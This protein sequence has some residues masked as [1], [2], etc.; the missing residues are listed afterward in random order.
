MRR[1]GLSPPTR[2]SRGRAPPDQPRGRS[3]PA[4]TGKPR[5]G[6]RAR[7]LPRVYPRPHGEATSAER[8]IKLRTGLSPPTRGSRRPGCPHA[9]RRGS[10]P[11]H[12]GKPALAER[13]GRSRRVYPRPHGEARDRKLVEVTFKGLSPP[14]RGSRAQCLTDRRGFRSIPAH[15]GKP[16]SAS[17]PSSLPSVYPRPHGEAL[18]RLG[19]RRRVLGL[20]P[21]TRGSR[22]SVG[23]TTPLMRSIPAHTGKPI[24]VSISRV[25]CAVYPRPHG[26]ARNRKLFAP[27][28]TG[29][30]PPTR[31]SHCARVASSH[32]HGSIPA[33]T[34]KPK[35]RTAF[36]VDPSV[37]PRPHGEATMASKPKSRAY[38]LSPPTRGSPRRRRRPN[39][40]GRS[41]P[42]HTGKPGRPNI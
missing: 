24:G 18:V 29:L 16:A 35:R 17:T 21:P 37:Y 30:S 10:I 13:P 22:R 39:P 25:V 36:M 27:V 33:H 23:P 8:C 40:G 3:I 26:E 32:R 20:S 42:A 2:G 34:G 11:A 7:R 4:H 41:I 1:P 15:T 5:A 14:T 19:V 6:E 31:G 38:G 28:G 12:T 9:R